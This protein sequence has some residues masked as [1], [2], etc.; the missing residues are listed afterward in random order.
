MLKKQK[1][2]RKTAVFYVAPFSSCNIHPVVLL[3]V[4]N[5]FLLFLS[6]PAVMQVSISLNKVELSVGESKFFICTGTDY[7]T[8]FFFFIYCV[9]TLRKKGTE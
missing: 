5:L 3:V 8:L 2:L 1:L 9:Y 4:D 6:L 7:Q